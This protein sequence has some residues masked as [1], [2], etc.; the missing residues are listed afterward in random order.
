MDEDIKENK[1]IV[2]SL[3]KDL[4]NKKWICLNND[5]N[6][7]DTNKYEYRQ[8]RKIAAF[9]IIKKTIKNKLG[10]LVPYIF[11]TDFFKNFIFPG[12]YTNIEKGLL[13]I[14]ELVTGC[15][16]RKMSQFISYN[17]YRD[18]HDKLYYDYN[19]DLDK[20]ITNFMINN[21]SNPEIR[22]MFTFIENL[23]SLNITLLSNTY[24]NRIIYN[25]N[26]ISYLNDNGFKIQFITDLNDIVLNVSK[27]YISE[28]KS[29][30][31]LLLENTNENYEQDELLLKEN[32]YYNIMEDSDMLLFNTGNYQQIITTNK[33]NKKFDIIDINIKDNKRITEKNYNKI[34]NI[35]LFNELTLTFQKLFVKNSNRN[36]DPDLYSIKI[37]LCCLFL[38]IKKFNKYIDE[39]PVYKKWYN[40][41]LI[42]LNDDNNVDNEFFP[43]RNTDYDDNVT[44]LQLDIIKKLK[45]QYRNKVS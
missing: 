32:D 26:K 16:M 29:K 21:F 28:G 17:T 12:P 38:N 7:I 15:S 18:I 2:E 31:Q 19:K 13:I 33:A 45:I 5:Y 40:T 8:F 42:F 11:L 10:Y 6:Y 23:D 39:K 30:V 43:Y 14:Y 36:F 4:I 3:I 1:E 37:K 25:N 35:E 44:E 24:D 27:A 20:W 9:D 22:T 34:S 41:D